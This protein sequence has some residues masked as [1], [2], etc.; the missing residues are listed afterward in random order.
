[1][2]T[3]ALCNTP[4][5]LNKVRSILIMFAMLI[6][7]S[8]GVVHNSV[9]QD[10]Y[11]VSVGKADSLHSNILGETRDFYVHL[12]N[13]GNLAEGVR[14]P[15][16][17]LL[18]GDALLG[19]LASVL[20]YHMYTH[21]PEV[22]VVAIAAGDH[23]T[24]DLTISKVDIYNNWPVAESG[25]SDDFLAFLEKELMPHIES[26][27]PTAPHRTLI[28]HSFAGLFTIDTLARRSDLF[29]IFIAMDPTL[30]WDDQLAL[31]RMRDAIQSTDLSG[32]TLFVSLANEIPRFSDTLT[33][34]NVAQD[35]TEFS[36][37][38]RTTLE[39]ASM[40]EGDDESG[41]RFAWKYYEGDLHGSVP[42]ISMIDGMMFA[43]DWW[44]L[45]SPSLFNDP[46][47]PTERLVEI[48]RHRAE[49]L[50]ANL[51]YP[52]AM[53]EDLLEMMGFMATEMDQLDKARAFF[54]LAVEYYPESAQAHDAIADFLISQGETK[55]ALVHAKEAARISPSSERSQRLEALKSDNS[56]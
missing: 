31:Q 55:E 12:P 54:E 14:Y 50:T 40:L 5:A 37:G 35:T 29:N 6:A 30:K 10:S 25:G 23:R 19:G 17:Y 51:G 38:M 20:D 7:L 18:D 28:G 56:N 42:L 15:V 33:I 9:A 46:F 52:M 22:I 24:R 21:T 3:P 13:G 1:M 45:E 49:K 36:F 27:Y 43:F 16:V 39:F 8:T 26:M 34:D 2:S 47:T 11:L 41:L 4:G 53:E 44:E 32:K 48:V